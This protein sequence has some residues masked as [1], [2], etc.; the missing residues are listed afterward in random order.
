MK[1]PIRLALLIVP[2]TIGLIACE[3][4]D[5]KLLESRNGDVGSHNAGANCSECHNSNQV[6]VFSVSG[7]V[8][9]DDLRNTAPNGKI[10]L[11]S[12]ADGSGSLIKTIE[13]D[14]NGNFYTTAGIDFTQPVYPVAESAQ[15]AAMYMPQTATS[16]ACNS[17]HGDQEAV[18][19]VN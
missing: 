8:F 6:T 2:L 3:D 19:F 7:T 14:A 4:D 17:C 10:M 1:I 15:G 11:Y 5:T 16:G 12:E 18:I 13:V 9:Q